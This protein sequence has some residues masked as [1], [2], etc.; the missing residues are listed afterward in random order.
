MHVE[1]SPPETQLPLAFPRMSAAKMTP[2]PR[3]FVRIRACPGF[4]PPLRMSADSSASPLTLKPAYKDLSK[5]WEEATQDGTPSQHGAAH[6]EAWA[7]AL[8]AAA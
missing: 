8:C 2:L 7:D 3:G 1:G 4:R 6:H 5:M